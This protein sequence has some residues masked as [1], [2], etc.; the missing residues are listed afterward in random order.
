MKVVGSLMGGLL[1]F[2]LFKFLEVMFLVGA[3]FFCS[4]GLEKILDLFFGC[5]VVGR[6]GKFYENF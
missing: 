3:L 1:C 5:L 4:C 6:I 2:Y